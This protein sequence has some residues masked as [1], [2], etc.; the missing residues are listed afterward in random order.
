MENV[1]EKERRILS[2]IRLPTS[3]VDYGNMEDRMELNFG[4]VVR[5]EVS[6]P[7]SYGSPHLKQRR[8]RG[9]RFSARWSAAAATTE[10]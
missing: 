9:N 10:D 7:K 6:F 1:L 2:E 3:T 5:L 8:G 4:G